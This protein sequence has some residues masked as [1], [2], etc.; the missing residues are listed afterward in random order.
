MEEKKDPPLIGLYIPMNYFICPYRKKILE[1][2]DDRKGY[3]SNRYKDGTWVTVL[4][5]RG[6]DLITLSKP[7]CYHKL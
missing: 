6:T 7:F 3:L 5:G 4:S 2:E 1:N